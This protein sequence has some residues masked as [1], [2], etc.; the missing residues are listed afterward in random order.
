MRVEAGATCAPQVATDL[1]KASIRHRPDR[2][3][4]L[5]AI[6]QNLLQRL[7]HQH[8]SKALLPW[9]TH[10]QSKK[11]QSLPSASTTGLSSTP[12]TDTAYGCCI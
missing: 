6:K 8:V 11:R 5:L 4:C 12:S 1:G 2:I 7:I 3:G 9:I 10:I